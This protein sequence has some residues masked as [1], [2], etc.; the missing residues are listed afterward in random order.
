MGGQQRV[1]G[2][3]R[4]LCRV[5][6]VLQCGQR[7]LHH[8]GLCSVLQLQFLGL[9]LACFQ[10]GLF[11]LQLQLLLLALLQLFAPAAQVLAQLCMGCMLL[12]PLG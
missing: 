9:L 4:L 12:L 1:L 10:L 2:L 3:C 7:L 11:A 5:L 6:G 8:S